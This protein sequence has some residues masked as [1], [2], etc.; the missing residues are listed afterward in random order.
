MDYKE[1]FNHLISLSKQEKVS[2]SIDIDNENNICHSSPVIIKIYD[3]NTSRSSTLNDLDILA[4]I[5]AEKLREVNYKK[6]VENVR[7]NL[8]QINLTDRE[9]DKLLIEKELNK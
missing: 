1:F 8:K 3:Y 5:S 9:I 6:Y 2:I 7:F 4:E